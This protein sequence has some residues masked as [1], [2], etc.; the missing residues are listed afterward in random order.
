MLDYDIPHCD[1]TESY[2][3][4]HKGKLMFVSEEADEEDSE[5]DNEDGI[6]VGS[7]KCMKINSRHILDDGL[8]KFE[9]LDAKSHELSFAAQLLDALDGSEEIRIPDYDVDNKSNNGK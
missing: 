1:V 5:L 8:D 7:I 4:S 6:I 2:V 3:T 9:F